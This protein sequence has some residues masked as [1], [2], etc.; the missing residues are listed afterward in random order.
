MPNS[1]FL[2]FSFGKRD[3]D[4]ISFALET[5]TYLGRE[6]NITFAL[7]WKQIRTWILRH[8]YNLFQNGIFTCFTN[9]QHTCWS[10][11]KDANLHIQ[12]FLRLD[13]NAKHENTFK[14]LPLRQP[15]GQTY[16]ASYNIMLAYVLP[17]LYLKE[18]S[19]NQ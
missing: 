10:S 19:M 16:L 8:V 1:Q 11:Q 3:A 6:A 4:Q 2:E 9:R 17:A 13:E 18:S 15:K 12:I 5:Q 7:F 14:S